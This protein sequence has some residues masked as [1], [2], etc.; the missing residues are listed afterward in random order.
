MGHVHLTTQSFLFQSSPLVK[1]QMVQ[2][3]ILLQRTLTIRPPHHRR[4]A[5]PAD[6]LA[7]AACAGPGQENRPVLTRDDER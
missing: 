1:K 4:A 3:R 6:S 2:M 5:S 7:C